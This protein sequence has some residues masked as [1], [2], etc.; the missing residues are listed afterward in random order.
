MYTILRFSCKFCLRLYAMSFSSD[1]QLD[2]LSKAL[3]ENLLKRKAQIR[4]RL[5]H[6]KKPS[7]SEALPQKTD[8][9]ETL[10]ISN[11]QQ[12]DLD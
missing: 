9:Q 4:A 11:T 7:D 8:S 12:K 5:Q 3:R 1:A 6:E 2:R 10:S